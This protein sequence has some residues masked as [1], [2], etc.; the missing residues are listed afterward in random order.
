MSAEASGSVAIVGAGVAGIATAYY[1]ARN[2]NI[3]DIALID[4]G[5]PMAFTSAQ[6]GENY[7]NW[8]P[9]PT[10]VAFT[11]RSIDLMEEIARASGNRINLTRRGY[12]LATRRADID[13]IVAQLR[14]GLGD[15]AERLVRFH[16]G[17]GGYRQ[18]DRAD[19]ETAPEGVDVLRDAGLIRAAFPS[20]APDIATVIH[21]RRAGDLSGQQMGAFMLERLREAGSR[22]VTGEVVGIAH[23]GAY[24]IELRTADG[25]HRLAADAIVNAGG[26]FA[27]R[28]AEMLGETLPIRNVLQ[29]KVA[30]S[31]GQAAIPRDLPFSIDLD[32]QTIDWTADEQAALRDDPDVAWLAEAMPGSIHCRPDGG[33]G[34]TWIKLG[35]AFNDAAGAPAWEPALDGNFPEIVLRGAARLNPALTAYYGQLP[36]AMHHYGGYYA[37]TEENWPLIGPCGPAGAFVNGAHSGF[38][39]MGACAAGEIAAAWVAGVELPAYA[40][41]LSLARYDDAA[42]MAEIVESGRGVL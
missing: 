33:D 24:R 32:P 5:Q 34:G 25:R 31:D 35:W 41:D 16:D 38:G 18:A 22:R 3:H 1:L 40:N 10:M 6:S 39:T 11:D 42:L 21:I 2:H 27:P 17:A 19:W 37:M 28:I 9:H 23:D 36:R 12:A 8:W 26:P 20:F 29:Q 7:R 14:F 4:C 30:F 13:D 15:Q